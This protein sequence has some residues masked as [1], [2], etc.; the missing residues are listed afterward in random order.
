MLLSV[1]LVAGCG[2]AAASTAPDDD[3]TTS[4]LSA[5]D[6]QSLI[7]KIKAEYEQ[8]VVHNRSAV[9]P[10]AKNY[11]PTKLT[12]HA[13]TAYEEY[14]SVTASGLINSGPPVVKTATVSGRKILFVQGDVS[15]T[16]TEYGFYDS[17]GA[18]LALAYSGQGEHPDPNGVDW[19]L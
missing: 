7:A 18:L 1:A 15:D 10:G 19:E 3:T 17:K 4:D 16:G 11:D 2:G 8:S 13:H 12:H 9:L 14:E 5:G 6:R